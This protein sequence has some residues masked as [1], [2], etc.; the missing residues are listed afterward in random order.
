V[1]IVNCIIIKFLIDAGFK[2]E[3]TENKQVENIEII[4]EKDQYPEEEE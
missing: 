2:K 4:S 1:P 3:I